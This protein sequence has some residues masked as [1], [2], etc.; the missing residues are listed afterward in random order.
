MDR[1]FSL[2]FAYDYTESGVDGLLKRKKI[3]LINT[4][5]DTLENYETSGLFD[6]MNKIL[7]EIAFQFC[8]IEVIGH[9]Y[10]GSVGS[11]SDKERQIM[12]QEVRQLAAKINKK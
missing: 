10:F 12:L 8:G 9:K 5:G 1:V 2:G 6:S 11:C 3:F 7:D 4:L